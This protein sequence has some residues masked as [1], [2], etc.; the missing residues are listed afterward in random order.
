MNGDPRA[1]MA[2]QTGT[3]LATLLTE[4]RKGI[5]RALFSWA[6][7]TAFWITA[8]GGRVLLFLPGEP[9]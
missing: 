4:L 5:E 7:P 6:C 3:P 2:G 1:Y 8:T 9:A